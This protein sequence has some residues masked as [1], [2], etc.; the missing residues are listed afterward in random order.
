MEEGHHQK[1][2]HPCKEREEREVHSFVHVKGFKLLIVNEF[3]ATS[4][5]R[6]ACASVNVMRLLDGDVEVWSV[7]EVGIPVVAVTTEVGDVPV[8]VHR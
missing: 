3:E 1:R 4:L 5:D 2:S 8:L 7:D 6:V